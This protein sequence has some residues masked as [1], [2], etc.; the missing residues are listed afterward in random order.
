MKYR[1]PWADIV[2]PI[3][4]LPLPTARLISF[5][6]ESVTGRMP[7]AGSKTQ[8]TS[9]LAHA[10]GLSKLMNIHVS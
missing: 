4:P 10:R 3:L 1:K 7:L 6:A 2:V 5:A 9:L 8:T